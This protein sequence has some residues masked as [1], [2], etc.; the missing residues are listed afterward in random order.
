MIKFSANLGFLYFQEYKKF[1]I[2]SI[3]EPNDIRDIAKQMVAL[4]NIASK[5]FIYEQF[6]GKA[7]VMTDGFDALKPMKDALTER[8]ISAVIETLV[9]D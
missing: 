6:K 8:G 4:P 3:E 2:D 1:S 9:K 5:R 7:C